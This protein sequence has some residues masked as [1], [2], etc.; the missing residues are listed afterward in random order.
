M[1]KYL[2]RDCIGCGV[3]TNIK[4]AIFRMSS[5]VSLAEIIDPIARE[6]EVREVGDQCPVGAIIIN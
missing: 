3:C 4:P 1:S 6:D 5:K 2:I